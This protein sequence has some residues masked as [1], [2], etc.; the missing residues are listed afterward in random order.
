MASVLDTIAEHLQQDPAAR[1]L[2]LDD[3]DEK[4]ETPTIIEN[5]PRQTNTTATYA[6]QDEYDNDVPMQMIR[7]YGGIK[8]LQIT[9]HLK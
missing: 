9:H 5:Q 8:R 1:H 7:E 3:E 4:S 6:A 2:F